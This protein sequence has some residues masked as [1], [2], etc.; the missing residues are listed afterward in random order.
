[1]C[2]LWQHG[3]LAGLVKKPNLVRSHAKT[4]ACNYCVSFRNAAWISA[5]KTY[6]CTIASLKSL[7]N[8]K[9]SFW[10][11][12]KYLHLLGKGNFHLFQSTLCFLKIT[13][14]DF[15]AIKLAS[16]NKVF[17]NAKKVTCLDVSGMWMWMWMD[18]YETVLR[19][20]SKEYQERQRV[21]SSTTSPSYFSS[22]V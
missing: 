10:N 18:S 12:L 11:G 16:N 6:H 14:A 3:A 22:G 13:H 21:C 7:W 15:A 1:M 2:S 8:A 20:L 9:S 19:A 5:L 17:V 4:T